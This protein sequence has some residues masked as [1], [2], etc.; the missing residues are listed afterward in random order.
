MSLSLNYFQK[1]RT[2]HSNTY[3]VAV[4]QGKKMTLNINPRNPSGLFA[5]TGQS[6][7]QNHRRVEI[8]SGAGWPLAL[9]SEVLTSFRMLRELAK[10]LVRGISNFETITQITQT[11]KC[12]LDSIFMK[13][14]LFG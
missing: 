9:G 1:T 3:Q 13:T 14:I 7:S 2:T 10:L 6:S 8:T 5:E 11:S 4:R 12:G